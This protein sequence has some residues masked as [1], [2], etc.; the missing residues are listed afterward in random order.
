[1]S[2]DSTSPEHQTEDQAGEDSGIDFR[3]VTALVIEDEE[4]I[5]TV[6]C[7]L[8]DKIGVGDT[9]PVRNAEDALGFVEDADIEISIALVDLMLPGA[10]G[11]SFIR[12][13][14]EHKKKRVREL[15]LVVVT[16]YTS[17]KVY[18][19][20]AEFNIN[21][22]LR[23][24]VAPG[25]LE[26]AVTKALGGKISVKAL[27]IY[28]EEAAA[29]QGE[30]GEQKKPGFF[31]TLFGTDIPPPKQ[32]AKKLAQKKASEKKKAAQPGVRTNLNA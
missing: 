2:S 17:M 19:R 22:F 16:S 6:I 18:K 3:K 31:A 23:K 7:A 5:S 9:I 13:V 20:A 30:S 11:L 4:V 27:Q 1:M 12:T 8:L 28:R 32:S 25:A 29:L 24:P 15:P 14:R 26:S 21:G 10:S